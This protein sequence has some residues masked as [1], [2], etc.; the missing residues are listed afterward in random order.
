[1]LKS[2]LKHYYV[3]VSSTWFYNANEV[4]KIPTKYISDYI[5]YT[6]IYKILSSNIHNPS[7]LIL[8]I[9]LRTFCLFDSLQVFS[10][11]RWIFMD[12]FCCCMYSKRQNPPSPP[13]PPPTSCV[14]SHGLYAFILYTQWCRNQLLKRGSNKDY[15]SCIREKVSNYKSFLLMVV[16]LLYY[17]K[18]WG[19]CAMA[20]LCH[21]YSRHLNK[22]ILI[23]W[24]LGEY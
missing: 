3:N 17:R 2:S 8:V 21:I 23:G 7:K 1:M 15:L 18:W 19:T 24:M 6:C 4:Q 9:H 14:F 13:P 20:L 12:A 5:L 11:F 22:V 16:Y 10:H